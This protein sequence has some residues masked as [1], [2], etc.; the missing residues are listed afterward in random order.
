MQAE[1]SY[2]FVEPKITTIPSP[3]SAKQK[4][5]ENPTLP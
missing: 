5:R 1:I 2:I 3:E 4:K